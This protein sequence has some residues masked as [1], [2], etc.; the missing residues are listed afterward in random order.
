MSWKFREPC[1]VEVDLCW[2]L[3]LSAILDRMLSDPVAFPSENDVI[4]VMSREEKDMSGKQ[5]I[6][7]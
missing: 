2:S 4:A 7:L 3:S 6:A 5:A 1:V